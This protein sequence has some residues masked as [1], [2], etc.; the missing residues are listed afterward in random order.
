MVRHYFTK[1]L[2]SRQPMADQLS[3]GRRIASPTPKVSANGTHKRRAAAPKP[4]PRQKFIFA[5]IFPTKRVGRPIPE[6][7][8]KLVKALEV[9][10][11]CPVWFLV[12]NG[13]NDYCCTH[14]C[15]HALSGFQQ[16]G[17]EIKNGQPAALLIQ[18]PGG[19]AH[20]AYSI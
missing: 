13:D 15:I 11:Q 6:P 17:S 1:S 18:S 3:Q 20:H 4:A 16:Q 12:N 7:F 5:S 14:I 9:V 10:T 8:F 19:I 2:R